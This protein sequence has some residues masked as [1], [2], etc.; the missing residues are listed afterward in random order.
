MWAGKKKKKK[1]LFGT[2]NFLITCRKKTKIRRK[3][4]PSNLNEKIRKDKHSERFNNLS[5]LANHIN[6]Q[7]KQANKQTNTRREVKIN[8]GI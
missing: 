2:K 1:K 3:K 6:K 5:Q 4:N 8:I 7:K